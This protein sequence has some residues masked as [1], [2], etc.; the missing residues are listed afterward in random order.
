M[1]YTSCIEKVKDQT[2]IILD[3]ATQKCRK[4]IKGYWIN[5]DGQCEIAKAS[6]CEDGQFWDSF[7]PLGT[8]LS[9]NLY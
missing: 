5:I 7:Y 9:Y 4:C 3:S 8:N 2:C 1:D 6:F